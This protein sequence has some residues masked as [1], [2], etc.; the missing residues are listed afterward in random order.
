[1]RERR[2]DNGRE[3]PRIEE[4]EKNEGCS[5]RERF[6]RM[7][8]VNIDPGIKLSRKCLVQRKVEF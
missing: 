1:M 5:Q 3:V 4:I 8:L 6:Q 2:W 7:V